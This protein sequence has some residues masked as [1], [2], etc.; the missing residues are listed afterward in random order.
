M[1]RIEIGH[2]NLSRG[3]RGGERQTELLISELA[4]KGIQQKLICRKGSKIAFDLSKTQNLEIFELERCIDLRLNGHKP[5]SSC[6]IIQAHEA[7]AAQWA[8]LHKLLYGTPYVITRRVPEA[9][10]SNF[11]NKKIY[12]SAD[13]IVGISNAICTILEKTF[14][15]KPILIPSACAHFEPNSESLTKLATKYSGRFIVGNIGAL[16]DKHKGQSVL[17]NA[18]RVL[19][20]SIPNLLVVF[21]GDGKDK[22][23]LIEQSKDISDFVEFVGF[24][25]NVADYIHIMDVFA[26][27][28]NYE[29]LGSVLLDVM[30]QGV[31]IVATNV[32]GI[33]DI[34]K[35]ETTGLL[36]QRG[37]YRELASSILRLK[38]DDRLR[39][40][41]ILKG[42]EL[43]NSFSPETMASRYL[44]L[45][46]KILD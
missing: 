21:L 28:S 38:D 13:A 31:P 33:P 2:V 30:E 4:K 32:D 42:K 39:S 15:V 43:S 35:N 3:F 16:V 46:Y 10:R 44:N 23:K 41:V 18:A 17:I 27:P 8:C 29:G 26:Y 12:L 5:L 11:F 34:V 14:S 36:I 22:E 24:V 6:T 40:R 9:I 37:N 7:R 45:Y 25:N 19:K 20:K 1:Q